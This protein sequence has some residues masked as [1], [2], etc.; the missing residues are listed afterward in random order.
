MPIKAEEHW[1]WKCKAKIVNKGLSWWEVI[2]QKIAISVMEKQ[3]KNQRLTLAENSGNQ[4]LS[5]GR[6]APASVGY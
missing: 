4:K 6:S 2:L 3:Q 1:Y 5:S